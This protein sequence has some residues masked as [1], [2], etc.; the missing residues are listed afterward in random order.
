HRRPEIGQRH[1]GGADQRLVV[2]GDEV[3][4]GYGAAGA[5]AVP[6]L[7][8]DLP[9][10]RTVGAKRGEPLL[11]HRDRETGPPRAVTD[12]RG[13]VTLEEAPAQLGQRL[14]AREGGRRGDPL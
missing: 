2:L 1:V 11:H 6:G 7:A 9:P 5:A 12:G 10:D 3:S 8:G 14:V 4:T 13:T